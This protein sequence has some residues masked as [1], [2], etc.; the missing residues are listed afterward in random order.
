MPTSPEYWLSDKP[1]SFHRS[2][3]FAHSSRVTFVRCLIADLTVDLGWATRA[4][5]T[6]FAERIH[7]VEPS[8]GHLGERRALLREL[9]V[10]IDS[11]PLSRVSVCPGPSSFSPASRCGR[12]S[13]TRFVS[14]R[15]SV[16]IA[17]TC[18][19]RWNDA[20]GRMKFAKWCARAGRDVADRGIHA[21]EGENRGEGASEIAQELELPSGACMRRVR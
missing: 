10:P 1:L 20:E 2:T 14:E 17:V 19:K 11:V 18:E 7:L 16:T 4:S 8:L 9:L 13:A 5:G 12:T 21:L 6:V 15:R 3:R